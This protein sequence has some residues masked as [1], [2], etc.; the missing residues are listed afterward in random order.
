[1]SS[2]NYRITTTVM[3]G[4]GGPKGSANFQMNS[5]FDQPSS[6]TEQGM[7]PYSDNYSLLPGFWYTI[8]AGIGCLYD[9]FLDGDVDGADLAEFTNAF[10]V[11]ELGAF[12]LEFGG[13]D[14]FP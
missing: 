4:G 14:C 5:T 8:G 11:G 1:M 13:V 9:Y 3:S 6:S 10:S 7:D 2:G 12:S